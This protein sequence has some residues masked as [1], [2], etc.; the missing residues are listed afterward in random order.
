MRLVIIRTQYPCHPFSA[1][2]G[3]QEKYGGVGASHKPRNHSVDLYIPEME[4]QITSDLF[5]VFQN[6]TQSPILVDTS[7][8]YRTPVAV[9]ALDHVYIWRDYVIPSDYGMVLAI[10]AIPYK[11]RYTLNVSPGGKVRTIQFSE[12]IKEWFTIRVTLFEESVK[13]IGRTS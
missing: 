10:N 6:I 2:L 7:H 12:E 4:R 11:F 3:A 1:G 9:P 5:S 13:K 8:A